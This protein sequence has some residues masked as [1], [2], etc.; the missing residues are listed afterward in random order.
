[1]FKKVGLS[2]LYLFLVITVFVGCSKKQ[3]QSKTAQMKMPLVNATKAIK[4]DVPWDVEYPAQVAGSL[5]VEIRAQVGGILK[6]RLYQEGE[7]VKKDS[8][9]FTIDP[10]Q[11]KIALE[12]AQASLEQ[13]DTIVQKSQRDFYRMK[14]LIK[15]NAVSQKDYDDSLSA[16][17]KAQADYK[18]AKAV[19]DDAKRNLG[20]TKVKASI[21]GIARKENHSVG[22]L[23]SVVGK[24]DS[25]LTTMVQIN[26][27]HINFS[28]PSKQLSNL[29]TQIQAD[30]MSVADNIDVDIILPDDNKVYEQSGKII[31]FDSAQDPKTSA[32]AVKVEVQNPKYKR[33]LTP[34]QFVKVRLKGVT[35]KN[36]VLIPQ[37]SLI[38]S[39]TGTIVYVIN[40][41]SNNIVETVAVSA[42]IR[43]FIAI[44]YSGLKGGETIV[45]AG[46]LKV[47]PS[48]PVQFEIK[49]MNLPENY[50]KAY[51]QQYGETLQS[52][53]QIPQTPICQ[54]CGMPIEDEKDF[55]TEADGTINKDYCKYC[56]KNGKFNIDCSL[57]E[58]IE[59]ET[60]F[61]L[62]KR[63][64]LNEEQTR[65]ML[66][67]QLPKL[68]RWN[69]QAENSRK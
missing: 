27:L 59:K 37:S 26:P 29:K 17:E 23:I 25:L 68:K 54:S 14:E 58:F 15:D 5:E 49:E 4:L 48:I 50:L 43:D 13:V 65:K 22:S 62:I 9:L 51:K 24:D 12:R 32:V 20:Y 44:V 45:S 53:L 18:A 64:D 1:M 19:V 34:G 66:Q 31:F 33:E 38:N 3:E 42:E 35:F 57:D 6:E 69:T 47:V 30:R 7:Y 52:D 60:K 16:Y 63:D 56:Y 39:P 67:E 2:L 55:G 8:V 46:S 36:A 11:Y 61:L 21:S 40:T 10:E 41:S 28:L